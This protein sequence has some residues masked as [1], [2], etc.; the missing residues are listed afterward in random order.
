MNIALNAHLLTDRAGYRAAGIH[1]YMSSV[2]RL[3]PQVAPAHWRFTALVGRAFDLDLPGMAVR[4]A[5]TDTRRPLARIAWEQTAQPWQLG[6]FDL[7]HAQAFVSPLMLTVPSVVTV[8]DLSFVH[9]PQVLSAARR[10]YLRWLTPLSCHRARRVIAISQSTAD[11]LTREFGIPADKIDVALGGYD[12]DRFKVLPAAEVEAF[13]RAKGLPD[14]FWLFIGTLEPRKNLVTLIEA[15]ARL[16]V[17]ERLPLVLGGGKGWLYD[18]IFSAIERHGLQDS[19]HTPGFLSA[20][21]LPLWYNSA[22]CFV[23]PSVYEGFG[24]PVLEAM[25][26]GA[27]VIISAASSLPEVGGDAALMLPPLDVEVW[28]ATLRRAYHDADWRAA[29]RSAGLARA[30]QFGWRT[31]AEKTI[32][33]YQ[34]A[35]RGDN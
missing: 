26:C 15:Y 35:V 17:S 33:S 21:D 11:D 6:G 16:P 27:P 24:L 10:L 31:T 18:D 34:Q 20:D 7:Y 14:R 23:Y 4:R 5:R 13:R 32:K 3:L 12:H 9:H 1:G 29:A 2:M 22:E 28:T 8:Y 25:A 19:I 30:G